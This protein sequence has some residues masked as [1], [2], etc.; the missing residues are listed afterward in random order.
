MHDLTDRRIDGDISA[1]RD[2][3]ID[4]A[5]EGWGYGGGSNVEPDHGAEFDAIIAAVEA[6]AEGRERERIGDAIAAARGEAENYGLWDW[7]HRNLLDGLD[8]AARIARGGSN[9]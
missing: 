9:A 1:L 7:A 4:A 8:L 2:V 6:R 3:Y 5:R